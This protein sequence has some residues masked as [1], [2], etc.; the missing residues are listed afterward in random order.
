M[1]LS[2][3]QLRRLTGKARSGDLS[4]A[5][6]LWEHYTWYDDFQHAAPWEE[7]LSNA[8]E[9]EVIGYRSDMLFSKAYRLQDADPMKLAL[10]KRSLVLEARYR[11]ATA[12]R[13]LHVWV[14]GKNVDMR[15]SGE[16]N[17]ATRN[18]QNMLARVEAAQEKR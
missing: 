1:K 16:P 17:E 15:Q 5:K 4:A 6:E 9:P 11:K 7:R 8:G 12:G 13:V 14:N 18:M 3:A 10:L 2:D